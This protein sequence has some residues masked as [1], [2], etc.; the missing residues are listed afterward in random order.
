MYDL[1]TGYYSYNDDEIWRYEKSS[2]NSDNLQNAISEVADVAD[3]NDIVYINLASHGAS[4]KMQCSDQWIDY[5]TL[6]SWLDEINCSKLII[7]ID[8]CHSGSAIYYLNNSDNP[9]DRVI[10]TACLGGELSDGSF[11]WE[12][13]DA[14][15]KNKNDYENAD[16]NFGNEDGDGNGYVSVREAFLFAFDYVN[17]NVDVNSNGV[18]DTPMESDSSAMWET[19]YLGEYR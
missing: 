2:A 13:T 5:T 14:L 12:F 15:G 10:Y 3:I 17:N 6:D 1:L 7:S 19:V 11:H 9:C 18:F 8:S 16:K 4:G